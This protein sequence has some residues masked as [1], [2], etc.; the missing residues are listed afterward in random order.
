[1]RLWVELVAQ[2]P[3]HPTTKPHPVGQHCLGQ[4]ATDFFDAVIRRFHLA[5]SEI[6]RG[7][8]GAKAA[9]SKTRLQDSPTK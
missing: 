5:N 1:M 2:K 8:Y 6:V 4:E 7:K 3:H 9:G